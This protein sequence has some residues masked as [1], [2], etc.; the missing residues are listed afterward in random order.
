MGVYISH[1]ERQSLSILG[2]QVTYNNTHIYKGQMILEKVWFVR[3]AC[4]VD[5]QFVS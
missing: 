1:S 2:S 4:S 5:S 3:L